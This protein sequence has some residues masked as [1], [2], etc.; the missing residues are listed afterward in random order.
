MSKPK[1]GG[2][3]LLTP[4]GRSPTSERA[5]SV[6]GRPALTGELSGGGRGAHGR[7]SNTH[8]SKS[9]PPPSEPVT[10][11]DAIIADQSA[12]ID[13]LQ[14]QVEE[15]TA[16]AVFMVKVLHVHAKNKL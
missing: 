8:R 2:A 11:R 15:L 16:D 1:T 6:G 5:S 13:L 10:E 12:E 14:K 7:Q 4:R 9:S 3:T